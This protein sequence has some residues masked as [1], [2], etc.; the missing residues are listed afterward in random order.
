MFN[1]FGGKDTCCGGDMKKMRGEGGELMEV[2]FDKYFY[3]ISLAKIA[4]FVKSSNPARVGLWQGY[5]KNKTLV[6]L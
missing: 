4:T 1:L 2:I 6:S 5:F 3:E